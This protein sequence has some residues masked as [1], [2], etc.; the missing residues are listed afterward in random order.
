[1][2]LIECNSG[3]RHYCIYY[4]FSGFSISIYRHCMWSRDALVLG[5]SGMVQIHGRRPKKTPWKKTES[6]SRF[7][8]RRSAGSPRTS[9]EKLICV[10]M[11][12]SLCW[13]VQMRW[14]HVEDLDIE[15]NFNTS[16]DERNRSYESKVIAILRKC[17]GAV[18]KIASRGKT[19]ERLYGRS[20]GSRIPAADSFR[21]LGC[22]GL[23]SGRK[24]SIFIVLFLYFKPITG[25]SFWDI[26][27]GFSYLYL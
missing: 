14:F 23:F 21:G 1:M 4:E 15:V 7:V 8:R 18:L 2:L 19:L 26:F 13:D 10:Q 17:V 22:L 25:F 12:R 27:L 3:I 6:L 5:M 24:S 11:A 16:K 9:A 20:S